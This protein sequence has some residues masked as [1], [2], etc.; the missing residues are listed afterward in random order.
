M[1]NATVPTSQDVRLT[2]MQIRQ[3]RDEIV[4]CHGRA[5]LYDREPNI[6]DQISRA[7][8]H[9]QSDAFDLAIGYEW[10]VA[11]LDKLSALAGRLDA[12]MDGET[13]ADHVSPSSWERMA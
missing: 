7:F 11:I 5:A 3:F 1:S 9:T 2:F 4:H 6:D 8:A 13:F 12:G 10:A